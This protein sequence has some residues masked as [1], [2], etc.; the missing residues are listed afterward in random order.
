MTIIIPLWFMGLFCYFSA[1]V[2]LVRSRRDRRVD[3]YIGHAIALVW[4][5][6]VYLAGEFDLGGL[7]DAEVRAGA[8]RL[9]VLLLVGAITFVNGLA[10]WHSRQRGG[11]NG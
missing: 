6:T 8:L 10:V 7:G 3:G 11:G 4:L 1:A 2:A 9:P 5:G